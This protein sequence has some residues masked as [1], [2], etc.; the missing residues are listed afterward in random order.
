MLRAEWGPLW[1]AGEFTSS[2]PP[3]TRPVA[4]H[5]SWA[6]ALATRRPIWQQPSP[7]ELTIRPWDR[8]HSWAAAHPALRGR[9]T[10]Q[11]WVV[12]KTSSMRAQLDRPLVVVR[13]T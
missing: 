13:V 9:S 11:S 10:R 3:V 6:A 12:F 4:R 5:Q 1:A 2:I 7:A 8:I